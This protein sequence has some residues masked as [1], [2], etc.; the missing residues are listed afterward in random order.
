MATLRPIELR[1]A[2]SRLLTGWELIPIRAK[3]NGRS[4]SYYFAELPDHVIAQ[5]IRDVLLG[6]YIVRDEE[7]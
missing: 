4:G 1:D 6:R 5:W 7:T 2:L 3:V